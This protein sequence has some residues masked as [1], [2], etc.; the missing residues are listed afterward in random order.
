MLKRN[1]TLSLLVGLVF[2]CAAL[3]QGIT[4]E[5]TSPDKEVLPGELAT[6]VFSLYN[7]AG[8]GVTAE[9][10]VD[11]PAGWGLL[12][13]V[14]ELRLAPGA[15]ELVFIT[16]AV[17]RTA[18]AGDY[19][20]QLEATWPGGSVSESGIVR[21]LEVYQVEVVAPAE[22]AG[23]PGDSITYQFFVVNRGNK[24]GRFT[25]EASSSHD[26]PVTVRP[27]EFMLAPGERAAVEVVVSIPL[28]TEADRDLLQFTASSED[29]PDTTATA[30]LFT[31]VLPP[32]PE[33]VVGSPF[34]ELRTRIEGEFWGDLLPPSA[35]VEFLFEVDDADLV[36]KIAVGLEEQTIV[37]EL[38]QLFTDHRLSLPEKASVEKLDENVWRIA[39]RYIVVKA[40]N[41]LSVY[42][43]SRGALLSLAADGKL[44]GGSFVFS[45][46]VADTIDTRTWHP[47]NLSFL[48]IRERVRVEA[49]AVAIS[50]TPLLSI[51]G[52]GLE[53]ELEP[54]GW[55][56]AFLSGWQGE[57]ARSGGKI[58]ARH[59]EWEW[60]LAY[61]ENRGEEQAGALDTWTW[62][63]MVEGLRALFE[64]GLGYTAPFTDRALLVRLEANA[65]PPLRLR[66]DAFSVGPYFP[67]RRRDQEGISLSGVLE[68][69]PAT[70]R[71]AMD[72]YWDNVWRVPG[73]PSVVRSS[74]NITFQWSPDEW[75]MGFSS[76]AAVDRAREESVNP[77]T[78]SRTRRLEV[79]LSGGEAPLTFSLTGR[80]RESMDFVS[81]TGCHYLEYQERFYLTMQQLTA[82]LNLE[83]DSSYDLDWSFLNS[84]WSAS[85]TLRTHTSPH[86]F[87]FAWIQ[88]HEGGNAEFRLEYQLNSDFS[89]TGGGS[90]RW[91]TS[92]KPV[93]L[94]LQAGFTYE[95][96]W[97]VPFL[98]AKGWVEGRVFFDTDRDGSYEPGEDGVKAAVLAIGGTRVSTDAA[99]RFKFPPL[100]PGEYQVK[101]ELLPAR[102]RPLTPGPYTVRIE[103]ARRAELLIPCELMASIQGLVYDDLNQDGQHDPDEPGLSDVVVALTK[104]GEEIARITTAP[105]GKF[106]FPD[107]PSGVYVVQLV[108]DTLPE[109]YEPTTPTELEVSLAQG[110]QVHLE[111]GAWQRP[112]PIVVTYQPPFADFIWSPEQPLAGQ[113]TTFD[114]STSADFDGEITDYAWDFDG[115]GVP[116]ASGPVVTWTFSS[117]GT[118]QVS[119]TVTDNDGNQDTF[120]QEV[121]VSPSE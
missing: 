93:S 92:G 111:F 119:L 83:Q 121:E 51:A 2:S 6:H 88:S 72:H 48:Y 40:G 114:G 113:P 78:D 99:G 91:D 27:R 75:P 1:A 38:V 54:E 69:E 45:L 13:P 89:L 42:T 103:V 20:I 21:V 11:Y 86:R 26:W 10:T 65:W 60:G 41:I 16:L 3:A 108:T 7:E 80:W 87:S 66:F 84:D 85:L 36:D 4:L 94:R 116:D 52:K 19:R 12:T 63:P 9:L 34:A 14:G 64:I 62:V 28:G 100:E 44:L 71:F 95:F 67:G 56:L 43:K 109:R 58:L 59:G 96:S 15:E 73:T 115:D 76:G 77:S 105:G 112:R 25:T 74:L 39:L 57:E 32:T 30:S 31:E 79:G 29:H 68:A 17:P 37:E 50:L 18:Q 118:Y 8:T 5:R 107:L 46:Q 104:A 82:T 110:E 97:T 49:G 81:G 33:L 55:S 22:G 90:S 53:V 70:F 102:V 24:V 35:P 61:R 120:T 98:P 117:P 23:L 47:P 101:L 106:S